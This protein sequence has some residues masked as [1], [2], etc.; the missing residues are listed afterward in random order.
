MLFDDRLKQESV[1]QEIVRVVLFDARHYDGSFD[2][3]IPG[4]IA[5]KIENKEVG[6]EHLARIEQST[7]YDSLTSQKTWTD[8]IRLAF[9]SELSSQ[10]SPSQVQHSN[11]MPSSQ[12]LDPKDEESPSKQ[13]QAEENGDQLSTL[14]GTQTGEIRK[15]CISPPSSENQQNPALGSASTYPAGPGD[16]VITSDPAAATQTTLASSVT[17]KKR[18]LERSNCSSSQVAIKRSRNKNRKSRKSLM[19]ELGLGSPLPSKS[20][21]PAVEALPHERSENQAALITELRE[22]AEKWQ[23]KFERLE[24]EA[25]ELRG[26]ATELDVYKVQAASYLEQLND[27][28]TEKAQ[29]E[30]AMRAELTAGRQAI[31]IRDE[32]EVYNLIHSQRSFSNVELSH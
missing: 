17:T 8:K 15:P 12:I 28:G 9:T 3:A 2:K 29:G 13:L 20:A 1:M 23:S 27:L 18:D 24:V 6:T 16:T 25:T 26:K 30:E 19:T 7:S 32:S 11:Q 21:L 31:I 14:P 22:Q 4:E 5:H 10:D